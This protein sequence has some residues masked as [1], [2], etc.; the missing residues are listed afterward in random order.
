MHIFAFLADEATCAAVA[1]GLLLLAL[2]AL[3]FGWSTHLLEG[4]LDIEEVVHEEG[5]SK[6]GD[7]VLRQHGGMATVG[8]IHHLSL[9]GLACQ[10][11]QTVLTEDVEALE[12]LG[13]RVGLQTYCTGQLVFQLLESLLGGGWEFSHS[14][15]DKL[16]KFGTGYVQLGTQTK[17]IVASSKSEVAVFPWL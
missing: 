7:S 2:V 14:S 3:S 17:E 5:T 9:W 10:M 15:V 11:L 13:I 8:A 16:C 6:A 1:G 12:Q 4:V